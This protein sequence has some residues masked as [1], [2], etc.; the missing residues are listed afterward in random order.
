MSGA[1]SGRNYA[2]LI[3]IEFY[4]DSGGL[5]S[6]PGVSKDVDGIGEVLATHIDGQKNF[7]VETL[8]SRED[9]EVSAEMVLE[10][11]DQVF[12]GTTSGDHVLIYFSGHAILG[13]FGFQLATAEK[14]GPLDSGVSFDS[15]LYR[16]NRASCTT[17][18]LLDCCDAG[19]AGDQEVLLDGVQT[20]MTQL[21]T[22]VTVLAACARN[23]EARMLPGE[24]SFYTEAVVAALS[25]DCGHSGME[26]DA[27]H[28]DRFT[29]DRFPDQH[30]TLRTFGE[31]GVL[32]RI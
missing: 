18:V 27:L 6:L 10:A 14:P 20:I 25:G 17:T 16:V 5:E 11:I 24:M 7:D 19:G 1:A 32:R 28:L 29:R 21:R 2:L 15:I 23:E 8:V 3:G 9:S 26:V 4:S 22:G 30:P 13:P 12:T 31:C